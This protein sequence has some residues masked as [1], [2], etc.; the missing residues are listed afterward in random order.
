MIMT[1][2]NGFLVHFRLQMLHMI[3]HDLEPA[4]RVQLEV[5]RTFVCLLL[6]PGGLR[7]VR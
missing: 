2:R 1:A 7:R 3:D 4:N 5:R 6:L